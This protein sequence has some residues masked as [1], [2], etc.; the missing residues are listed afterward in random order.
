MCA[1]IGTHTS[2][3]CLSQASIILAS[4]STASTATCATTTAS[5]ATVVSSSSIAH[6]EKGSEI[7][8]SVTTD[9]KD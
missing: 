4:S 2:L 6:L 7:Y 5:N 1:K 9:K 3:C 8:V